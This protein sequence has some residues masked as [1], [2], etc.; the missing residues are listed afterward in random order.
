MAGFTRATRHRARLRMALGGP[1]GSGKTFT[2]LR[3]AF[4]IAAKGNGKVAVI[5]TESGAVEK[6]SGVKLDGHEWQFDIVTLDQYAPS[7]YTQWI[8]MAGREGFA[9]LVIDSLSHAWN[10][11]GGA[12]EQVS[13]KD[14]NSY[15]AWKDVTP[16]HQAMV[17]SILR[18]PCHIIATMRTKMEYV[19][20]PDNRGKMVPRKVGMAPIQRSGMEYEFDVFCDIDTSHVLTVTKTRCPELDGQIVVKPGASFVEPLIRWLNDGTQV[21][22][23][24]FAVR[25]E[26]LKAAFDVATAEMT[27]Q[28][29]MAKAAADARAA[30]EAEAA[31]LAAH[32]AANQPTVTP[33]LP[34]TIRTE[35]PAATTS[36]PT[37]LAEHAIIYATADQID[38]IGLIFQR[39]GT[40]AEKQV[41][42]LSRKGVVPT[43]GR[44]H[45]ELLTTE[46]AAA[47]ITGLAKLLDQQAAAELGFPPEL[48]ARVQAGEPGN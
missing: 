6:Y 10:G 23:S 8:Q 31:T 43:N 40:P 5:N 20:E 34:E 48:V 47:L 28:E 16:Q 45:P 3:F 36:E 2:A 39:L 44:P 11:V 1:A 27:P 26:D 24:F 17:E 29:K 25:P 9:V 13:K 46:N 21:D 38:R 41:E 30:R 15:T 32:E 33:P 7:E 42:I 37:T 35:S 14:G 22:E 18:S 12:L 4:E 19:L